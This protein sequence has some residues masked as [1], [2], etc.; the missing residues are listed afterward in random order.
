MNDSEVDF[1]ISQPMRGA[2][3]ASDRRLPSATNS[4][5]RDFLEVGR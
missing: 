4:C 3:V 1:L 5:Q 2:S